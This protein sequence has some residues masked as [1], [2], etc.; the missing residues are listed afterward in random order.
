MRIYYLEEPLLEDDLAF[1]AEAMESTSALD[2]VRVP[3]VLPV[4]AP[5]WSEA[6]FL[7]HKALLGKALKNCGIAQDRGEQVL[8][9][10]PAH[11]Y[12]YSVLINAIHEETGAYP[13]LIQTKVQRAA[14]GNPGGTRILDAQ[15]LMGFKS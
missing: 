9:V 4:A 1:V 7:R 14:I 12:W 15:G 5:S 13:W 6:D 11:M 3:H 10:A 2:Q 8:F